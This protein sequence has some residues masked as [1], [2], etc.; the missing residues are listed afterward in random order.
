MRTRRLVPLLLA[1]AFLFASEASEKCPMG[2]AVLNSPRLRQE[3]AYHAASTNAELLAPSSSRR[4]AVVAP[5]NPA[6]T[7]PPAVN[8]I[9]SDLFSAMQKDAPM[10]RNLGCQDRV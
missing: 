5:T 10:L 6:A 4:R 3:A 8:F 7:F 2:G 1:P 9:D